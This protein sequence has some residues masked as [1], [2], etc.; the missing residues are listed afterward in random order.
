MRQKRNIFRAGLLG[1]AASAITVSFASTAS[2]QTKRIDVIAPV[3]GVGS[4]YKIS[5]E[6]AVFLG[7][8]EGTLFVD[9]SGGELHTAAIVCPVN[10]EIELAGGKQSGDGHCI[11]TG[12]QGD[13]IF[14]EW[15]CSGHHLKGCAGNFKITGGTGSFEGI[16][17]NSRIKFRSAAHTLALDALAGEVTEAMRGLIEW[18]GLSYTIPAK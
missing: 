13:R 18:E 17:G 1:I 11:I 5:D 2:A 7:G 10:L 8:V 14:A 15:S 4:V 6:N 16:K 3:D 12:A 9:D